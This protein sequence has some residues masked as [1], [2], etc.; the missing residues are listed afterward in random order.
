[1]LN[2]IQN[3][4]ISWLSFNERV[5]QE[6]ENPDVPLIE[7]FKFLGICSSNLDEFYRVRVATLNRLSDLGKKAKKIIGEDPHKILKEI[8]RITIAQHDR[9]DKI[10]KSLIKALAKEN[11]FIITE[12]E[13]TREQGD[14]VNSY[15]HSVLRPKLIPIMLDQ[16]PDKLQLRDRVIYLAVCLWKTGSAE[17]KQ[18]ALIEIP[19]DVLPR[20]LTIPGESGKKYIIFLDDVIRYRLPEIFSIFAFDHSEAFTIKVTRD[21]ELDIDDDISESYLEKMYRGLKQRKAGN[22]VRFIYDTNIPK[23]LLGIL[24]QKLNLTEEDTFIAGSKYHNNRDLT[25]FPPVGPRQLKYPVIKSLPHRDINTE[26]GLL[27]SMRKKDILL[28]YPYQSFNYVIDLLR[29]ASIDP[30]VTSIKMTIYRVAQNS[31]VLNALINAVKNGKSVVVVLELRARF[32]E[33]TNIYWAR[34][35][36]EEKVKVIFGVPG[37]KVHSKL[38]L[39][40]RTEKNRPSY[41]AIIGTGNFNEDTARLYTDHALFTADKRLTREVDKI[42]Q[43]FVK[44]YRSDTFKHLIVSPN[45]MR[46]RINTLINREIKNARLGKKAAIHLKLN[47]LTDTGLIRKLYEASEAGVIIRLIVRGMFSLTPGKENMSHN[48]QAISIVD[49][50]LEHSRILIFH[51]DGDEKVFISSADWMP[52]NIDRRIEV[53]CPIYDEDIKKEIRTHF[54]IQWRDNVRARILDGTLDNRLVPNNTKRKN[55]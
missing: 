3:K 24:I 52:R 32:D 55:R 25:R 2:G 30:K 28:H 43:F 49:K 34:R 27:R 5:L 12:K 16:A 6:A 10:F 11:I 29:E 46:N 45:F 41:Y 20:F 7:R 17:L 38:C 1:M 22:P 4:E 15:F 53:T 18:Y 33:E 50:F 39:I 13:L 44:T 35:L 54:D 36:E 37:L 42:F 23:E 40:T 26:K 8:T 51:N 47:N 19:S 48:I 9:F 14:F 31:S 21:A